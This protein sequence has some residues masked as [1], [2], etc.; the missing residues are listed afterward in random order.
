MKK[1]VHSLGCV[2]KPIPNGGA[3]LKPHLWG[4]TRVKLWPVPGRKISRRCLNMMWNQAE[5]FL[6]FLQK[7]PFK[8]LVVIHREIYTLFHGAFVS[9]KGCN[10]R[11]ARSEF[12]M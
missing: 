1:H 4:F 8:E 5:E 9:A 3:L 10:R 7:L 11:I 2:I 6:G 12:I